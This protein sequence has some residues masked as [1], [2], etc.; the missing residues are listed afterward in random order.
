MIKIFQVLS[1]LFILPIH[2]D[3]TKGACKEDAL[4]YCGELHGLDRGKCMNEN[5][6]RLSP[7]CKA[8]KEL[9]DEKVKN[10][11]KFCKDDIHKFCMDVKPGEGKI[12]KCLRENESQITQ[13]CKL[14]IP[15]PRSLFL[16]P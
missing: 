16:N 10:L 8:N 3:F 5:F 7:A 4:K 9:F 12:I 14:S 15:S 1:L 11:S 13:E 2:S 6:D